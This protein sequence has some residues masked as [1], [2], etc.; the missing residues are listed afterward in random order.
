MGGTVA[1]DLWQS[2]NELASVLTDNEEHAPVAAGTDAARCLGIGSG[3]T[4]PPYIQGDQRIATIGSQITL[5]RQL[6]GMSW[7][8]DDPQVRVFGDGI[9]PLSSSTGYFDSGSGPY[10]TTQS[11]GSS[12]VSCTES[13]TGAMQ[14]AGEA[15][16]LE[17]F[18]DTFA[19]ATDL[20]AA[21]SFRTGK[22][23]LIQTPYTLA[24]LGSGCSH[25]HILTEPRVVAQT[26]AYL[27]GM[28]RAAGRSADERAL[29][30][31]RWLYQITTAAPDGTGAQTTVLY[32]T[33]KDPHDD[34]TAQA[35][36]CSSDRPVSHKYDLGGS[37]ESLSATVGN[38]LG[39]DP[40]L[41]SHWLVDSD[42]RH[43]SF[44][45]RG[46]ETRQLTM[47]LT[48][49]QTLTISAY[50]TDAT[51]SSKPPVGVLGNGYA[52]EVK[53]LSP[54]DAPRTDGSAGAGGLA[55]QNGWPTT[56]HD[57]NPGFYTW[58]G[59]ASALGVV[60]MG[61]VDW[62]ACDA[63]NTCVAGTKDEVIV[64]FVTGSGRQVAAEFTAS[65]PAV[66]KLKSLNAT[67]QELQEL[68]RAG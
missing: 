33:G 15:L 30:R 25:I 67:D 2:V 35:L 11:F 54:H 12:T 4:Q 9:V 59:A 34:S 28:E 40:A 6:F 63:H 60:K 64:T 61:M 42:G 51:C 55:A 46:R 20:K 24:A 68:L 48:G 62:L 22:Y 5:E 47:D 17:V 41:S 57:S 26:A 52:V 65:E 10:T 58:L 21:D 36:G 53:N 38:R 49:V 56:R 8:L 13:A 23:E 66:D 3:C 16:H 19:V 50:S 31:R 43:T 7:L 27:R 18:T 44:D 39:S 37:Y 29:D 1:A 14:V 45:L 32:G